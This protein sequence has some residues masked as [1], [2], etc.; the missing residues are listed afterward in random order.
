MTD[1]LRHNLLPFILSAAFSCTFITTSTSFTA[2]QSLNVNKSIKSAIDTMNTTMFTYNRYQ[3]GFACRENG[4]E[5]CEGW[6]YR[7]GRLA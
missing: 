4:W 7:R 3:A 5:F 1:K 2:D 6:A